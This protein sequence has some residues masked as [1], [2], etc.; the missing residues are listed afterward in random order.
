MEKCSS[1]NHKEYDAISFCGECKIYI[2]KLKNEKYGQHSDCD[3]CFIKNIENE[4]KSKL[5]DNMKCLE[6]ISFDIEQ[7]INQLKLIYEKIDKDKEELKINIQKVFTKLRYALNAR[8]DELLIEVDKKYNELYFDED[9]IK[10]SMKLPNKIKNI[11][12]KRKRN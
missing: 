1:I 9:I 10:Q 8:E 12:R 6:D 4:K 3:I 7:K 2:S 11:I 5:K